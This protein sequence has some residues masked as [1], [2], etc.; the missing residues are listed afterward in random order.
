MMERM[1]K[2]MAANPDASKAMNTR[3]IEGMVNTEGER[4]AVLNDSQTS[5]PAVV[6]RT[7]ADIQATDLRDELKAVTV[8]VTVLYVKPAMAAPVPDTVFDDN[9]RAQYARLAGVKLT[10]IPDSAHFIMLDAPARFQTEAKAF[11]SDQ[12]N[13]RR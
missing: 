8:P 9:Y 11:L 2:Q 10:R 12:S 6:A 1:Q 5:D 7:F 13:S 4:P 3:M